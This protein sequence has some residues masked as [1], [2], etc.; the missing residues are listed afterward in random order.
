MGYSRMY[1]IEPDSNCYCCGNWTW[2]TDA[3]PFPYSD[4]ICDSCLFTLEVVI[5][6]R[7]LASHSQRPA[8]ASVSNLD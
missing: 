6:G 1:S 7:A 3:A 4:S 8:S 5:W 2:M